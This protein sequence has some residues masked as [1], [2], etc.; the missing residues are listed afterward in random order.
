MVR[1]DCNRERP[2]PKLAQLATAAA[3]AI[4]LSCVAGNAQAAGQ[5]NRTF[6][7]G[8]GS[9][10]GSCGLS[11][12]CRTFAY[13]LTQTAPGGEIAVLDT[14]GYG[15]V[16]ITQSVSIVNPGGVEAGITAQSGGNAITI[17]GNG[18]ITVA[19]RGL[20]L[21]GAGGGV[22]GIEFSSDV[23]DGKGRLEI[24]NCVIRDFARDGIYIN[25]SASSSAPVTFAITNTIVSDNGLNGIDIAPQ[26]N[27]LYTRGIIDQ[28]QTG[29]NTANGISVF[30]S[31]DAGITVTAAISNT[32]SDSNYTGVLLTGNNAF[33]DVTTST[34]SNNF[35]YGINNDGGV[36]TL[37]NSRLIFNASAYN[38]TNG[39]LN[40]FQSSDMV[41]N[42]VE[43]GSNTT[44]SGLLGTINDVAGQ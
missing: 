32:I 43:P 42:P 20:T 28:V 23:S 37:L 11:A 30:G 6:V 4:A 10:T 38:E 7:S 9:D 8:A 1:A 40:T 29:H 33:V 14:A 39:T 25:P 17:N 18:P 21:E 24:V 15:P 13:A 31:G 34:L 3:L 35:T 5:A 27:V 36:V 2:M 41:N 16:T 22:N 44:V 19:L 26:Q 12:P